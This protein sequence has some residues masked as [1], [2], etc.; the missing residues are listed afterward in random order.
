MPGDVL[1][2][3]MEIISRRGTIGVGKAVAKVDGKIAV[4]AELTFV[5]EG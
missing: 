4:N 2:L 3:D 1:E 5:I